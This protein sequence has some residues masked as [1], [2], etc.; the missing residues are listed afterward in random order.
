MKKEITALCLFSR[1]VLRNSSISDDSDC[2]YLEWCEKE[3][4]VMTQDDE[5]EDDQCRAVECREDNFCA[6]HKG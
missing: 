5:G 6:G 4:R 1:Y 3:V 2:C